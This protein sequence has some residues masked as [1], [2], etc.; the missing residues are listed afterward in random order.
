MVSPVRYCVLDK[1]SRDFGV[2]GGSL[3]LDCDSELFEAPFDA[4]NVNEWS[5][6]SLRRKLNEGENSFLNRPRNFTAMERAAIAESF[7]SHPA[8]EDGD[9]LS[10]YHG[11]AP[12]AGEKIFLLDAREAIRDSYGFYPDTGGFWGRVKGEHLCRGSRGNLGKGKRGSSFFLL[13]ET[14]LR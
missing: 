12:L 6:S 9:D 11:F 4:G 1:A 2:T 14:P 7:K 5:A 13:Q 8:A 3:L 10:E